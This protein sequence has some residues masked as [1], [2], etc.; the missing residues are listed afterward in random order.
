[1]TTPPYP[2]VGG[3]W[4][5]GWGDWCRHWKLGVFPLARG[6]FRSY[7]VFC[8]LPLL[9]SSDS[10]VG[11]LKD[12]CYQMCQ[13]KDCI[14]IYIIFRLTHLVTLVFKNAHP[15]IYTYIYVYLYLYIYVCVC[16]CVCVNR[17]LHTAGLIRSVD[18]ITRFWLVCVL[19][20]V[21][22]WAW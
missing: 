4:G 13:S 14:H 12:Q 9:S 11:I 3:V 22:L 1:M 18:Q 5:V 19:S 15:R 6:Y 10:W 17:W 16:V 21:N 7:R 20:P 2:S 8:N